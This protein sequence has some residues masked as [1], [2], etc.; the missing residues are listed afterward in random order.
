MFKIQFGLLNIF[1][2][3]S[4]YSSEEKEHHLKMSEFIACRKYGRV[5]KYVKCVS[6]KTVFRNFQMDTS[7][8]T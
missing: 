1:S 6:L 8:P 7:V 2:F 3:S 4:L 5:L